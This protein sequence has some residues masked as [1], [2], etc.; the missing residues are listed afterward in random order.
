MHYTHPKNLG[1]ALKVDIKSGKKGICQSKIYLCD[2]PGLKWTIEG[3][4]CSEIVDW[5]ITYLEKKPKKLPLL[6]YPSVTL[7]TERVWRK[8][9]E[10]PF[11]I[12]RS[13]GQIAGLIG[14][15][16]AQRA[17]GSACRKNQIMLFLP[18]HRVVNAAGEAAGGSE[19]KEIRRRLLQFEVL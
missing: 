14:H 2:E 13:Y 6:D 8:M 15:S 3:E 1:P 10:I 7:F 18:C 16:S 17:V 11:G 4:N 5:L 12:T 19:D 9:S